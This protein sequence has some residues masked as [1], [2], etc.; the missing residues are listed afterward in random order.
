[1]SKNNEKDFKKVSIK[2]Q[3]G[4]TPLPPLNKEVKRG[5]TPPPSLR[6]VKKGLT[7]PPPVRPKK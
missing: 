6:G 1:M 4:L 7:P 3:E 5:M 2:F